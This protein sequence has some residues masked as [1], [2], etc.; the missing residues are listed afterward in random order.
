MIAI[1]RKKVFI[2]DDDEYRLFEFRQIHEG[3]NVV[4]VKTAQEAIDILSKDIDYDLISL[5]H[6]LGGEVYCSSELENSGYRVA[7]YLSG[8]DVK[9]KIVIHSWNPAGAKRMHDLL[10][11]SIMIPFRSERAI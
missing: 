5:D 10:P 3:S 1:K 6:D 7:K 2:L 11:N 4:T 8:K 9:C